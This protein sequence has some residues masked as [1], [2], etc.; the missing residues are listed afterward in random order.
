MNLFYSSF[1]TL[2]FLPSFGL[3]QALPLAFYR[4]ICQ[5]SLLL[6]WERRQKLADAKGV[7]FEK[8][9]LHASGK[10]IVV[11]DVC[12]FRTPEGR[13]IEIAGGEREK[14]LVKIRGKLTGC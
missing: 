4:F 3:T 6:R 14:T 2:T 9:R 11:C 7:S 13:L 5:S 1:F 8:R 12:G 10:Y